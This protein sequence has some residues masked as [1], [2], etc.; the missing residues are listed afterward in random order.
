MDGVTILS[1]YIYRKTS[2]GVVIFSGILTVVVF[3]LII[4]AFYRDYKY[5]HKYKKI[6]TLVYD[7]FISIFVM[8]IWILLIAVIHSDYKTIHVNYRVQVDDSV[9]F[10]EF[11]DHYKIISDNG[12]TYTVREIKE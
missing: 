4:Y 8:G 7:I 2:L 12:D 6:G 5:N 9:F 3:C 10:N 11:T 1:E